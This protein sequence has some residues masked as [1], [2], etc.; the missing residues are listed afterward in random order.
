[1][2]SMKKFSILFLLSIFLI[3]NLYPQNQEWWH[4]KERELR[5]RP[6][7]DG[8]VIV[9]GDKRFN[10]SLY[11][12][13][14]AFRVE[15]GDLP[16]FA[17]F[18]PHMGGNLK[19]GLI[20]GENSKWL[21]D[22]GQI[23]AK[24]VPGKMVYEIKDTWLG[25][26]TIDIEVIPFTQEEG[27]LV[28][29]KYQGN[30]D[31]QLLWVFGGASGDSFHRNG[32]IG[33]DP[34]SVF[35]LHP[36]YC[37]GDTFKVFNNSFD[38]SYHDVKARSQ[39][40]LKGLFPN[41]S[42]AHIGD[43]TAQ[44][45]PLDLWQSTALEAPVLTVLMP[46][47]GNQEVKY[48]S[49]FKP[50]GNTNPDYSELGT[51]ME[52]AE[53]ARKELASRVELNTPDTMLNNLAG[54]VVMAADGVWDGEAF[55]HGAVAW[56][57]PLNGWR[58]ASMADPLGWGNRAKTH[59]RG[60]AQAQYLEP[61]SGPNVP[62]PAHGLARQ[63]KKNGVS[64]YTEGYIS[65]YPGRVSRPHHYDMNLVFIDQII[66]HLDW[67]GDTSFLREIWPV[68]E[69]HMAWEKRCFDGNND[70]LY[71]AYC[72]IWA[73]DGLQYSGGGVTHSSAYNYFSNKKVAQLASI[74][75]K[76]PKPFQDEAEKILN[77]MN[78][79]L[80]LNDKGK[81][82]EYIDLLGHQLIH[83]SAAVW[84]YYH[85]I[86]SEVPDAFQAY[87][88][89][90]S[91]DRDIPKIPVRAHGLEEGLYTVSTTN[92]MPY[93]WSI[94]NVALAEVMHTALAFWQ[95]GQT[96]KAFPLWR[97]ALIESMYL[98]SCPGNMQQLSF[99][100]AFRGELYRDFADPTAMVVRSLT[101]GLFGIRPE[102]MN[103]KLVIQ[104]G[105]PHE[106]EHASLRLPDI[107]I[108]YKREAN[109]HHYKVRQ[110]FLKMLDLT[111]KFPIKKMAIRKVLVNG[112]EVQWQTVNP[113][114]DY[115]VIEI[116]FPYAPEYDIEIVEGTEML[117]QLDAPEKMVVGE[118]T[119]FRNKNIEML[120]VMDPQ[121]ALSSYKLSK[122]KLDLTLRNEGHAT[123]FVKLRQ[124]GTSWW[125]PLDIERVAP[126]TV[127]KSDGK[128]AH[129]IITNHSPKK[130]SL[131]VFVNYIET[132]VVYGHMLEASTSD[133]LVLP[134]DALR[135]GRNK[136]K[137]KAK[138]IETELVYIDLE[139]ETGKEP[140]FDKIAIQGV[141]NDKVT[142]VFKNE[143][144]S[145]RSPFPTLQLPVNGI[146]N[147]CYNTIYA[148]IDDKGLRS[149]A[150]A[151]N[152]F[153][154]PNGI[155][156]ETPGDSLSPNIAF[157]SLWDNYPE[158]IT[159]PVNNSGS[160]LYLL[161]AG[162]T[163]PMQSRFV[164]GLV[165]V[166]Y[167]D[168]TSDSLLLENPTTWWPIEQ[169]YFDDGYAFDI[170]A[171]K[172]FRIHLKTG[173]IAR[174]FEGYTTIKGFTGRAIEGGAATVLDLPVDPTKTIREI[175]LKTIANDVVIG[176]MGAT[177]LK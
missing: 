162:T 161:M 15:A 44:A 165:K 113:S 88:M 46:L 104:P 151:A 50:F 153:T 119:T 11:G 143:Y 141:F 19:F 127:E 94:N 114:V 34:E 115:P 111:F 29:L 118:K 160:H 31:V 177:L 56:R 139:L 98:G 49:V 129:I 123:V 121:G 95:S 43:A 78:N 97:A 5:Y 47:P 55:M 145:P 73:S 132:P 124:N 13:H 20:Q 169:D 36:E 92:W 77:A 86:D 22:A 48:F 171:P 54:A 159:I 134:L 66:R 167:E 149:L 156:F 140:E 105:L 172:P 137:V 33:A 89:A 79:V 16:E 108:E 103:N 62:D 35:Y 52:A 39:R 14:T 70:G 102:A 142:Q 64:L 122:H 1:M 63:L 10:R 168:G 26:Q 96:Q 152:T 32:D 45:S 154:L 136:I 166:V 67:T 150:G 2:Q 146:G 41:E 120:E 85:T 75:G 112:Q 116:N 27:I 68:I 144:L 37:R 82:A 148:E 51:L 59:F 24:Y 30:S 170:G 84:S 163:N 176:I 138:G 38:M 17:L 9:N 83:P 157:T 7:G 175:Q 80:W 106:W 126:L 117:A 125:E 57:M 173:H 91:L 8:F 61:D 74:L 101:E 69:R 3:E 131:D 81:F 21:I 28:R 18:L 6:E 133:T 130:L 135:F 60:Y 4:G 23:K 174:E 110:N 25:H 93:T 147:W 53:Q 71:D 72:C 87:Q 100:D 42:E 107:A 158:S 65:R 12:S 128:Q 76:D 58:G 90:Q 99:Y 164:N 40:L 155:P 109:T